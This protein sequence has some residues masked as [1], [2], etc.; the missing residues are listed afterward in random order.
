MILYW[1]I[2]LQCIV[3]IEVKELIMILV[4]MAIEAHKW[5]D[6]DYHLFFTFYTVKSLSQYLFI[7][8]VNPGMWF[9][10]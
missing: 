10:K 4:Y 5:V 1:N 6:C 3:I 7:M 8:L 9:L 2:N